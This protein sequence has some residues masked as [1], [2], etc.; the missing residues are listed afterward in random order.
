MAILIACEESQ[1]VCKAFRER[2][3][4]AYSCDIQEPSGGQPEWHILGDAL[5]VLNPKYIDDV[6]PQD[7]CTGI[8]FCTMD[9]QYH[10]ADKWDLVI[11][12]PPC[13]HLAASGAM[14]FARKRQD[15]RQ[16][17]GIKFFMEFLRCKCDKVA[18]ENPIGIISGEYVQQYFPDLD[19]LPLKPTQIIQP[20]MFGDNY[21]KS[22]C[23]WLR[24]LPPLTP[25][26]TEQ[27]PLDWYEWIDKRSG[28][29][30]RQPL[31]YYEAAKK[32]PIERQR[33]RSK[34]FPGIARAMA[35]QWGDYIREE[36]RNEQPDSRL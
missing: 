27:P 5:K 31:W 8:E 7:R 3:F 15:G 28:K 23:L 35:E 17:D 20:W 25:E 29:K 24:G 30:K 6:A 4:D 21:S 26:V 33:L 18:V 12:H 10:F 9:G 14:H 34:T 22:T 36:M 19:G 13:T 11:A 16:R 2:G 32:A 1:T